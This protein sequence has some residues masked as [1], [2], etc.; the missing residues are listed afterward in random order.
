MCVAE[1]LRRI[2][3]QSQ[4][5]LIDLVATH[6]LQFE[7][8]RQPHQKRVTHFVL[9]VGALVSFYVGPCHRHIFRILLAL[10][11]FEAGFDLGTLQL[12]DCIL[13]PLLWLEACLHHF[14]LLS[15][16]HPS[17]AASSHF[18]LPSQSRPYY[19]VQRRYVFSSCSWKK[20]FQIALARCLCIG[21]GTEWQACTE[22]S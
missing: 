3:S 18:A 9:H 20:S 22:P 8:P 7:F 14:I 10:F 4:P 15:H 6:S 12:Y 1:F 17:S 11:H 2:S 21:N 13:P 19:S 16:S 5:V